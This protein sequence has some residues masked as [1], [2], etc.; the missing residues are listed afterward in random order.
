MKTKSGFEFTIDAKSLDNM[1]LIDAIAEL[2]T[3]QLAL[4][5]VL[6]LLLGKDQKARLYDHV[7]DESGRVSVEK[8]GA[9]LA[10]IFSLASAE[11][12]KS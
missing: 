4:P 8:I 6:T 5:K 9:E 11:L 7:R 10:D 3:N 2:E 1:E 12:K